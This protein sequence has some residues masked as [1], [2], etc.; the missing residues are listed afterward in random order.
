MTS[1]V[2]CIEMSDQEEGEG[3]GCVMRWSSLVRYH[4]RSSYEGCGVRGRIIGDMRQRSL[5]LGEH[6]WHWVENSR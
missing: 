6:V 3:D 2:G 4:K 1:D 5:D